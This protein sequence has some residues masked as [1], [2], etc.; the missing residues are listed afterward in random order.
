MAAVSTIPAFKTALRE[1]LAV[2]PA[3]SGVHIARTSPYPEREGKELVI[4]GRAVSQHDEGGSGGQRT[5]ALGAGR[6]EERY[7]V[8]L[9]VSV[10]AP[11]RTLGTVLEDRAY[12][13]AGVIELSLRSWRTQAPSPFGGVVRWALVTSCG[14]DDEGFLGD[15]K[16]R[17]YHLI[18]RISCAQRI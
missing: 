17:E 6:R 4:I 1:R 8:E 9:T 18:M 11:A 2:D 14:D 12:E 3:L 13:I 7:T 15:G 5:A 10:I 16:T